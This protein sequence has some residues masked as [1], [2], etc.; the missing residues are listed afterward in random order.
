MSILPPK[1]NLDSPRYDQSTYWGRARHF[2][3]TTNPLNLLVTPA[4]LE[5]AK[6]KV[7]QYKR[8]ELTEVTEDEIWAAKQLV[9]S[10]YHP[11]TGDYLPAGTHRAPL[12][13]LS[14]QAR[15]C[16]SLAGCP[17]RSPST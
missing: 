6:E 5:A 7:E 14:C 13:L 1:I 9:D 16:S 10:A 12:I 15:R 3:I 4:Q 2:F 11:E 8:G 17:P